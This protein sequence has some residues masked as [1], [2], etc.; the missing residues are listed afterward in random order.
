MSFGISVIN[1]F[2]GIRLEEAANDCSA[3]YMFIAYEVFQVTMIVVL[4]V[5]RI[6]EGKKAK[7]NNCE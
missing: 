7:N 1:I 4:E 3:Y 2:I 6:V 5:L